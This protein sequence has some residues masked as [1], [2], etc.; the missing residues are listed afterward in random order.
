MVLALA[1]RGVRVLLSNST[2]PAVTRLYEENR[3]LAAA[4]LRT[5]RVPARRAV[6]SKGAGRGP[7]E[8]L[9]VSNVP[10]GIETAGKGTVLR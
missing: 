8:E 4:G 2:A 5:R 10:A 7:I 3:A 1:Q 6:N 9:L